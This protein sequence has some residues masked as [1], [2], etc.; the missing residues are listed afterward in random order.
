MAAGLA[1]PNLMEESMKPRFVRPRRVA[2]RIGSRARLLAFSVLGD[3]AAATGLAPGTAALAFPAFVVADGN[4]VL[5]LHASGNG[6]RFYWDECGTD[7]TTF[8]DPAIAQVGNTVFM[9]AEGIFN[10][11][12]LPDMCKINRAWLRASG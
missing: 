2:R 4:S 9:A 11:L 12:D 3:A 8:C 5:A 10:R 6:L 1:I 7:S